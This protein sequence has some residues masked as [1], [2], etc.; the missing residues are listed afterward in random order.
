MC[1]THTRTHYTYKFKV[2]EQIDCTQ[3]SVCWYRIMACSSFFLFLFI[4]SRCGF[5]CSCQHINLL[6]SY[7]NDCSPKHINNWCGIAWMSRDEQITWV[8]NNEKVCHKKNRNWN[9]HAYILS[10]MDWLKEEPK[11]IETICKR[12]ERKN[13]YLAKNDEKQSAHKRERID[14]EEENSENTW[15][16]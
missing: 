8:E 9:T 7:L 4:L 3:L 2:H 6:F 12:N 5:F 14:R 13:I 10:C 15:R 16:I 11:L 1:I